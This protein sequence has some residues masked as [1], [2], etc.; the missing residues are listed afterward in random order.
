MASG[1][2]VLF[3][4][5]T[6]WGSQGLFHWQAPGYLLAFPLLGYAAAERFAAAPGWVSA[7]LKGSAAVFL[8][9]VSILGSH[10]ATGWLKNTAPE[11]FAQGD[12]TLESLNWSELGPV[13]QSRPQLAVNQGNLFVVARHWIEAGKIDYA[14][15]G[16]L[17]VVLLSNDPHHYPFMHPLSEFKGKDALIIGREISMQDTETVL[18]PYFDS[19]SRLD[20]ITVHRRQRPEILLNVYLAKRFHGDYPLPF[21]V[22]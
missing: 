22:R 13:L 14:L 1:P 18:K 11:A 8:L 19:I 20:D 6:L 4:A 2:I 12:P 21:G 7:W 16:A 10:T 15:G 17:P 3:T 5:A 9:V